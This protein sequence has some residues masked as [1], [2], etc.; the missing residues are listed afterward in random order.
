[1]ADNISYIHSAKLA[2]Y[3]QKYYDKYGV[4]YIGQRDGRLKKESSISSTTST[5]TVTTETT[6]VTVDPVTEIN[7]TAPLTSSGGTTPTL[8]IDQASPTSDGYITAADYIAFS[9]AATP[10]PI[11]R[12]FIIAMAVAL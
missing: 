2:K 1:M 11:P 10:T 9:T 5:T 6:E 12:G 8:G 4:L 7:V 3:G